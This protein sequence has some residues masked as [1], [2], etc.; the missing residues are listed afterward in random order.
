MD[1]KKTILW[2]HS[3]IFQQLY[4]S[5]KTKIRVGARGLDPVISTAKICKD[6]HLP[7]RALKA[8]M[9]TPIMIITMI[10]K[11]QVVLDDG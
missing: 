6:S 3:I 4:G 10:G 5:M 7:E 9:S 11:G 1:P 8:E 2:I